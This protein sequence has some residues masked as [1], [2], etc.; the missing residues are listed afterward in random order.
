M[1][2]YE[3]DG[4]YFDY[5]Y[6]YEDTQGNYIQVL[7]DQEQFRYRVDSTN[8][9]YYS[10][11]D[12][13]FGPQ[14]SCGN[15]I[16]ALPG[17]VVKKGNLTEQDSKHWKL[18]N[19]CGREI[20]LQSTK[21]GDP[22]HQECTNNFLPICD[23]RGVIYLND[24]VLST[25]MCKN[26]SL[27]RCRSSCGTDCTGHAIIP[28]T[29]GPSVG[30]TPI[31]SFSECEA[32][33]NAC[34]AKGGGQPVCDTSGSLYVDKCAFDMFTCQWGPRTIGPCSEAVLAD[35]AKSK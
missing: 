6:Y 24:C 14:G 7:Q 17:Q 11:E 10:C 19:I 23:N 9:G 34:K 21:P 22:C 20:V 32:A 30:E 1:S 25:E 35:Y 29:Y 28:A 3:E 13:Y 18:A 8:G 4:G 27:K 15:D 2:D 33:F 31:K 26:K 12:G 5:G 16:P